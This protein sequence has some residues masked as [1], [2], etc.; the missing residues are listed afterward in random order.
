[1]RLPF[2]VIVAMLAVLVPVGFATE[3]GKSGESEESD[4]PPAS[5][6]VATIA[7]RVEAL[8]G[9][10]FKTPPVPVRVTA[11]QTRKD[12]LADFDRAYPADQ[13]AAD[14]ALYETLG[15]LPEGTDLREVTGSIFA[16]Q[17]AGYYDPRT[18]RLRIVEGVATN[19]VVDEMIIAHELD[20]ALED[21]AI[22]LD[23]EQAEGSDDSGYAYTALVEGTAS[24]VMYDYVNEHFDAEVGLGG[25][26]ASGIGA[27][28]TGDLPP[29]IVAGLLF[30]Y[31]RGEAF[32]SD[33]YAR[34][35]SWQLVNVAERDRPPVST[36]QV[37]HPD[38]WMAAEQPVPVSVRSPGPGWKRLTTGVF[39]E[40]QTGQLLAL[41]GRGQ[42]EASEGWGGDRYALYQRGDDQ[43]LVM[44]WVHDSAR[45]GREFLDALR[46]YVE[47]G[48]EAEP[49]GDA[50]RHPGGA[51]AI[52]AGADGVTLAFAPDVALA[53][54]LAGPAPRA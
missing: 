2:V 27:P 48:L 4:A 21:Q 6:P 37:L 29:F 16:S 17:V 24:R 20:H 52:G 42:P 28:S 41:G 23:L 22:G 15:L 1:M 50:Y 43:A 34:T 54:R 19:R 31:L 3:S 47:D 32:V 45:D 11:E 10:D 14:E 46:T 36:E 13:R 35:D 5:A 44:H 39:G 26:L 38:K 51:I 8:R 49:D 12:G 30:P 53:R 33:L 7:A 25:M 9:L 18:K 40:W